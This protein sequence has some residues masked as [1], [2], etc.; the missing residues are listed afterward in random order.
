MSHYK[1]V[2]MRNKVIV[3][4]CNAINIL[5]A[6][7]KMQKSTGLNPTASHIACRITENYSWLKGARS[8][9]IYVRQNIGSALSRIRKKLKAKKPVET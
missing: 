2:N 7:R 6:D 9:G 1:Y 4:E 8:L 3:F 5:A